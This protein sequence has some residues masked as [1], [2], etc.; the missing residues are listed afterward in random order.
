VSIA[1]GND[2]NVKGSTI[3][4]TNDVNLAAVGNVTIT[5]S[6][7]TQTSQSSYSERSTGFGAGGGIGIS[8]GTKAQTDTANDTAVTNNASTVGSLNGSVNISAGKDLHVTGS[9][10]I[11]AQN[12]S[13]NPVDVAYAAVAGA[14]G[15]PYGLPGTVAINFITGAAD[16]AT[17][18]AIAGKHDNIV[19]GGL[20]NGGAAAI[21]FGAG[22]VAGKA[23]DSALAP[24]IDSWKWSATGIWSGPAGSNLFL[25]NNAGVI[26][27]GAAGA[28][29]SEVGTKTINDTKKLIG[30]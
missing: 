13:V 30:K 3:V 9:D 21:G 26:G 18:N 22:V 28:V 1:S 4:G 24:T 7:D 10:L 6:Q 5:T 20:I 16:T 19:A 15:A 8:Y 25:P 2:I 27:A 17:N 29:G 14:W 23:F 12:V 11:A